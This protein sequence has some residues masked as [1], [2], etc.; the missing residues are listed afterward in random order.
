M[1]G[2]LIIIFIIY[3]YIIQYSRGN[4]EKVFLDELL[5][6]GLIKT[7]DMILFKASNNFNSIYMGSYFGHMGVVVMYDGVPYLFEANGVEH[8]PL[9]PHHNK[10]GIFLTPL[11]ERLQKYKGRTFIKRLGKPIDKKTIDEFKGFIQVCLKKMHYELAVVKSWFKKITGVEKCRFNTNCGELVFL[12]LIKLGIIDLAEYDKR[13][14]FHHL[15]DMA[16]FKGDDNN[17]YH[18]PL[19]VIDVPFD[20]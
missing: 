6:S 10:N 12:S 19:E 8:M 20:K 7:G 1:I 18:C 13:P 14:R 2:W 9:K 17:G 4:Y 11:K 5:A 16:N 15:S 3:V